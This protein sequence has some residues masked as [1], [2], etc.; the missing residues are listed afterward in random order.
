MLVRNGWAI[1]VR[2]CY[3]PRKMDLAR[4]ANWN[5]G[6]P[7]SRRLLTQIGKKLSTHRLW[8][9]R[10]SRPDRRCIAAYSN[11]GRVRATAQF[12]TAH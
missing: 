1:S 10:R 4:R 8:C 7:G 5:E 3:A 6:V 2:G 12:D 9:L 11:R